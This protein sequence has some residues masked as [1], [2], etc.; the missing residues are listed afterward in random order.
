MARVE[1]SFRGFTSRPRYRT[2]TPTMR[3][4][5]TSQSGRLG[6]NQPKRAPKARASPDRLALSLVRGTGLEPVLRAPEARVLPLNTT[7]WCT[8]VGSNDVLAGFS[9]ALPPG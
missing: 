5:E 6:S 7:L 2:S 1:L 4:H 9:R 3:R 8:D